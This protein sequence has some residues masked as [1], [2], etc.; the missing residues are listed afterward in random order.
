[1]IDQLRDEVQSLTGDLI[2]WRREFHRDPEL[3]FQEHRTS[4]SIRDF[5]QSL[6]LPVRRCAETGLVSVLEGLP[7]GKTVAL[8]ADMDALPLHDEGGKEYQSANPGAC[9]ACGHDGHMSILMGV[10]RILSG[11]RNAFR[12]NVVFLFQPSEEKLPGGAPQMIAEGALKGV[13]AVFGLHLWQG[14]PTGLIGCPKGPMMAATDEIS[15]TI[16]GKGGHGSAP[17]AT[18]DPILAASQLVVNLQSIV[19]RNVDPL[20]AA[21]VSVCKMEGGSAHNII[22][23]KA[24]LSG[25]VRTFDPELQNLI[26]KKIGEII[27]GTCKAAGA[28][29]DWKYNRGYPAVVNDE[30]MSGLVQA[31]AKKV[32][33]PSCVLDAPP[34]MGGEDFAYYLQR[35]PGA[36]LFFGMGDGTQYPHHHPAF[37]LDE[38]ALP[39]AALLMSSLALEYLEKA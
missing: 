20:K 14:F 19:S 15:I 29:A 10:A 18:V 1:M 2:H 27:D 32:L 13:D 17:H 7:G 25:T 23:M 34:V 3:A 21:V 28:T 35:V 12:G 36:F 9:H 8:R 33:G 6:A 37:D 26:E 22:P 30:S 31:V 16:N 4:S 5:L 24:S 38:K 39:Q 11:R